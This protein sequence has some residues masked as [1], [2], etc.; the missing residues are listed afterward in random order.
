MSLKGI[1]ESRSC[2]SSLVVWPWYGQFGHSV[3]IAALPRAQSNRTN[4]SWTEPLQQWTKINPYFFGGLEIFHPGP[5]ML[6]KHSTA[7]LHREITCT[8]HKFSQVFVKT[9][10]P[11]AMH[12]YYV[13]GTWNLAPCRLW[14]NVCFMQEL[15]NALLL[16]QFPFAYDKSQLLTWPNFTSAALILS[17]LVTSHRS[18]WSTPSRSLAQKRCAFAPLHRKRVFHSDK[19]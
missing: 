7:K 15:V 2:S 4:W 19:P 8:L 5:S 18:C 14:R 16:R 11:V 10:N 17:L 12:L 3:V 9:N 6:A 1:T 13:C